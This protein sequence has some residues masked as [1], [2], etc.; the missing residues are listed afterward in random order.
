M[1]ECSNV[2]SFLSMELSSWVSKV[3]FPF[4]LPR[5]TSILLLADL[6]LEHYPEFPFAQSNPASGYLSLFPSLQSIIP[7]HGCGGNKGECKDA[8]AK[9]EEQGSHKE[10]QE[11]EL[12]F[13]GNHVF[14][15]LCGLV[16]ATTPLANYL[17]FYIRLTGTFPTSPWLYC[18]WVY[19]SFV[20]PIPSVLCQEWTMVPG[21]EW[22]CSFLVKLFKRP[23][24]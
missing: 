3:P 6:G 2:E 5:K 18:A 23:C 10:S 22:N 12:L 7:L 14:P 16:V 21:R 20:G 17:C 9:P 15:K 24:L 4:F 13:L 1:G 19:L 11:S 8:W